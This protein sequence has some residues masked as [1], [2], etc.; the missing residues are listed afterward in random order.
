MDLEEQ[1]K[2]HYEMGRKMNELEEQR[3]ALGAQ[4]AAQMHAKTLQVADYLVRRYKRLSI[5]LSV[6]DARALNATKLEE[7]V[8]RDKIKELYETGKSMDGVSEIEWIQI[9]LKKEGAQ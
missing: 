8:D 5:R 2:L 6:D 9:S 1:I 4:I 3:K 7:S